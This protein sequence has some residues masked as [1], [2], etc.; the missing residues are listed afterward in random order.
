M[1]KHG[2][3]AGLPGITGRSND[4][5]VAPEFDPRPLLQKGDQILPDIICPCAHANLF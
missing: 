4:S 5:I 3:S 1:M 2:V